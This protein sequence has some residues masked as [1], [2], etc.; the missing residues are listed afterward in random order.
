MCQPL[1]A[2]K[3]RCHGA[4]PPSVIVLTRV[5]PLSR[6]PSLAPVL[7]ESGAKPQRTPPL[8]SSAD[9]AGAAVPIVQLGPSAAAAGAVVPLES[10]TPTNSSAPGAALEPPPG[11]SKAERAEWFKKNL[12]TPAPKVKQQQQKK[13]AAPMSDDSA[14]SSA[15]T[16]FVASAGSAGGIDVSNVVV[17]PKVTGKPS[18]GNLAGKLQADDAKAVRTA[19]KKSI[20]K[21]E[22]AFRK[23]TW[24]AH[25]PQ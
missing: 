1:Q 15:G 18:T 6:F 20:V 11:L 8:Q 7:P 22:E 9:G 21:R 3:R 2:C 16:D 23:I 24:L 4:V 10:T 25:L 13:S 12:P 17:K 14:P 19:A 5:L